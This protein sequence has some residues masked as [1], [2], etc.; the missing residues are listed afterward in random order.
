V[1]VARRHALQLIEIE[2]KLHIFWELPIQRFFMGF[3][4]LM[5]W[6]NYLYSFIHIPG[7]IAFLAGLYYYTI[8]HTRLVQ[9]RSGHLSDRAESS[10][11]RPA[12]YEARR[13]T[14]A[15]CNLLAFVVFTIWPCMPPRLLSDPS[16]NG[17][18]AKLAKAYGFVDAVHG[19]EGAGSVWTQ[20]RFCNQYG[21]YKSTTCLT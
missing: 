1:H 7:S 11:S 15:L 3:T 4:V 18:S 5:P 21:E 10:S 14:M 13:R 12:L 16:Y 17:A 8:T 6:I 20:N 2:K 9:H 19:E